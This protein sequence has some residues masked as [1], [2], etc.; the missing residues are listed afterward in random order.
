MH[1]DPRASEQAEAPPPVREASCGD[2]K[3]T[4][5]IRLTAKGDSETGQAAAPGGIRAGGRWPG[6]ARRPVVVHLA[7]LVGYLG[8]GSGLTGRTP[9]IWPAG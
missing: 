3:G 6:L 8:A 9:P 2:D 4:A 1:G 5:S 7:V